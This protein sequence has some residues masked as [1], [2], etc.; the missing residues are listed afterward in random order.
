MKYK[1]KE[2]VDYEWGEW[3]HS[4]YPDSSSHLLYAIDET[5]HELTDDELIEFEQQ[6]DVLSNMFESAIDNAIDRAEKFL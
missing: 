6:A 5:G 2:I 3:D 1:G 4:D